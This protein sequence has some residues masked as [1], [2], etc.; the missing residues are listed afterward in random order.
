ML[1]KRTYVEPLMMLQHLNM[2]MLSLIAYVM[3]Q[4]PF[5][6]DLYDHFLIDHLED[7]V[8]LKFLSCYDQYQSLF[9]TY[10]R[11]R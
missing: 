1:A 4:L 8:H 6:K 2:L 10:D 5:Q 7:D 3:I 11:Q 9:D